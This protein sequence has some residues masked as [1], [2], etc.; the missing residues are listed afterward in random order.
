MLVEMGAHCV[1]QEELLVGEG[2]ILPAAEEAQHP[3][4]PSVV[5]DGVVQGVV[6]L[7]GGVAFLVNGGPQPLLLP[8]QIA[9][10]KDGGL[11]AAA[12]PAG[13]VVI[14]KAHIVAFGFCKL[15]RGTQG[16]HQAD[17][18]APLL[19][20]H[21]AGI[22][23]GNEHFQHG[24]EGLTQFPV[25]LA[26]VQFTKNIIE[27]KKAV[28]TNHGKVPSSTVASSSSLVYWKTKWKD[29]LQNVEKYFF[30]S[31]KYGKKRILKI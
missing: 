3:Q 16:I 10:P 2:A 18:S 30:S 29:I 25:G 15:C 1:A 31:I 14:G 22:A 28:F 26:L 7:V 8:Y 5:Y 17:G 19:A 24:Q 13:V 12:E 21:D 20:A 11:P 4:G 27:D 23:E 6:D 9:L